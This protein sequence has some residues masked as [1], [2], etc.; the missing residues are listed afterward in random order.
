MV[1]DAAS[2]TKNRPKL[3]SRKFILSWAVCSLAYG[4]LSHIAA[5]GKGPY[6]GRYISAKHAVFA[7]RTVTAA[8]WELP[9]VLMAPPIETMFVVIAGGSP[10][11]KWVF[12]VAG[13]LVVLLGFLA[14]LIVTGFGLAWVGKK[15]LGRLFPTDGTFLGQR[16]QSAIPSF[17]RFG[18]RRGKAIILLLA[19]FGI[20][21][22]I[23]INDNNYRSGSGSRGG[24][25]ASFRAEAMQSASRIWEWRFGPEIVWLYRDQ[26]GASCFASFIDDSG[27]YII[28]ID[29]SLGV[30]VGNPS[31]EQRPPG[32]NF[33]LHQGN[34]KFADL[35]NQSTWR[36]GGVEFLYGNGNFSF[37]SIVQKDVQFWGQVAYGLSD[38]TLTF[39]GVTV[40]RSANLAFGGWLN[41]SMQDCDQ[42]RK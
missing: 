20:V 9:Q 16:I 24:S 28:T 15:A 39:D 41:G 5:P 10:P 3:L 32:R 6:I 7:D 29:G 35:V 38:L 22:A 34:L 11:Y 18:N 26:R 12:P 4:I 42:L 23:Y 8:W 33:A 31:W 19:A 36:W 13:L 1:Q 17:S 37:L 21:G 27:Q 2:P 30:Y 25:F 40:K 14:T